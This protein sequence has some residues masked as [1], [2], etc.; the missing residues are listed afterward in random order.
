MTNLKLFMMFEY[1]V[2]LQ[3]VKNPNWE[4][5]GQVTCPTVYFHPEESVHEFVGELFLK[6]YQINFL[7]FT[8]PVRLPERETV[9]FLVRHEPDG[10]WD[11]QTN[12]RWAY[13]AKGTRVR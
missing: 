6:N 1:G 7:P 12:T 9:F 13:P 11:R 4:W 8:D 5:M 10:I 3:L 2:S